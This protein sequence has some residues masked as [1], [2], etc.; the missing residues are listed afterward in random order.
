MVGADADWSI[1]RAAVTMIP[2]RENSVG[3][4]VMQD[5]GQ[6]ILEMG[7]ALL[8]GHQPERDAIEIVNV[9]GEAENFGAEGPVHH[10]KPAFAASCPPN[11]YSGNYGLGGFPL[12][13]DMANWFVPPRFLVLRC[14]E[15]SNT[16]ATTLADGRSIVRDV[17]ESDL[18]RALVK[19]RRAVKGKHSLLRLYERGCLAG[20]FL[21]WDEKYLLPASPAGERG[22][23]QLRVA[24]AKAPRLD[25]H[26]ARPGDTLIV[27]NWRMLHGRG[28]VPL[29][30]LKRTIARAYLRSLH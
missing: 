17:G 24:V 29:D 28:S 14:I 21:R 27:D 23:N 18:A 8:E 16:V 9:L 20:P 7:F 2:Q 26:L 12:H 15:G 5:L 25:V 11:T 6:K 1:A 4:F 22:V 3:A 10:L 30:A 19:P 13:T